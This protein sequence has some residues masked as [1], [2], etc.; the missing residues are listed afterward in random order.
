MKV[1]D[2]IIEFLIQEG[3]TDIFGYPGGV[4]CHLI[5]SAT[6]YAD[7]IATHTNY[8][9]QA[10]AFAACGY[11]QET[12]NIGVAFATSGPGATNMV[13]GIANAYYDSTPVVFI[14]GQV[15]TYGLKG[16]MPI[17]QRGFQETDV[18][19][20]VQSIT[21]YAVRVNN[22]NDIRYELEKAF[23]VARSGNPGPVVLDLP[24]DVQRAEINENTLKAYVNVENTR[25]LK[26]DVKSIVDQL[27]RA[28]RPC[29]LVGN[30][31]KQAGMI[32]EMRCL[33]RKLQIPTVFSMPAFDILPYND[34]Y[35]YGFIGANGQ[36]YGNFILG[37][38][39]LIISIGSR[40]DLKQV[41]N[42]REEFAQQAKIVRIDI[43]KDAFCH[44][45]HNDE[46]QIEADIKQL[47][48]QLLSQINENFIWDNN[49]QTTCVRI[50][51]ILR[52][53][54]DEDYTKVLN[55]FGKWLPDDCV[56][57]LDVGQS[58]VW[59]CQQ[60]ETKENQSVHMS[61]GLGTMGYSLPAAIGAYYS[62]KK[63]VF[64]FNGD[65]GIQMNIQELQ[66][67]DREQ[68]PV[69]VIIINNH[70]LGMIR[71]FQEANFEKNYSQTIEGNGYSVPNFKKIAN[72]YNL[73][74]KL[75][76]TVAEINTLKLD[77][78][79]PSVIEIVLPN[80][81][82]LNPNFGRNGLIQDQRPYL[83]RDLFNE[84]MEM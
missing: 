35:N 73:Q 53:Y 76:Q 12:H 52:G 7:R 61:A 59:C 77:V 65:G 72:A 5:D 54:D 9:E 64:C 38:A 46:T 44:R 6:K 22:P 63:P 71:G 58:Q 25:N 79:R 81:T 28:K 62:H 42:K 55:A 17:R 37:K 18:V 48:P 34:E 68:L 50:K 67:L 75:I 83:E 47:L 26:R 13:T 30:G 40:L 14:T 4:I 33:I 39:D 43:D 23:T 3:V 82:V 74:Y 51:N 36:R 70:S 15:D 49:W 11:A 29:F 66:F 60:L 78:Q 69:H 2:Y 21:K 45:V 24:A 80:K 57:T 32:S 1:T 10:S 20:I 8:H 27:K 31:V 84:L 56:I 41:G 16:D 19:S